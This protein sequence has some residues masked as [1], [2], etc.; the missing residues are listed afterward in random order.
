MLPAT[1][2]WYPLNKKLCGPQGRSACFGIREKGNLGPNG[3]QTP[4]LP[5]R[6]I[7]CVVSTPHWLLKIA[8]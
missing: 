3:I 1:V 8:G 7:V 6:N 4:E 5:V 2:S